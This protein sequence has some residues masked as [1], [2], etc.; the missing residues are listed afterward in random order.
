VAGA[1]TDIA[2]KRSGLAAAAEAGRAGAWNGRRASTG[3][4]E[5]GEGGTGARP[6]AWARRLRAE[7]SG[8]HRR[9]L[10]VQAVREGDRPAASA[11]PDIKERDA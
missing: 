11:T 9:H 1:A 4:A 2:G 8:R 3:S 7:Q 6:P 5:A 10:V